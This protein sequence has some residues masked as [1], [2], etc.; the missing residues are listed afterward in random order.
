MATFVKTS[1]QEATI[2]SFSTLKGRE[3]RGHKSSV[4]TVGWSCDGRKLASGSVDKTARIWAPERLYDSRSSNS[5][6]LRG[7]SESVDQLCWDPTH[8]DHLATASGDKTVRIWDA[9][10]AKSIHT[11]A[12][13]GQN[14]NISWSPDGQHIAVGNKEDLITFIDTKTFKIEKTYAS[15]V[16]VN[17]I[18]WDPTGKLFCL[19]TG[20]G[21]IK[22]MDFTTMKEVVALPAHTANCYC[23]E[24]S[25]NGKYLAS[26]S[27]DA[28]VNLWDL[29]S[30]T[31]VRT[32]GG[33][34]WPIR[35]ISF[36]HDG[37][38]LASAS[39]DLAIEVSLV[40][41]GETVHRI[42][43][44]AAMNTVAWHPSKYLLAYAGEE[45]ESRPG[46]GLI[47]K[48]NIRV[49]GYTS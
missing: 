25:P 14:I 8:P 5:F 22:I 49:W 26:G 36:S 9:R 29:E 31:C 17:E 21:S 30:Y 27:A 47:S 41:T 40:E 46:G 6:E 35:T 20:Q 15:R 12:T 42:E 44:F 39:E 28:L 19:T 37:E 43:C 10:S 2:A 33:L 7:H 13:N 24:F 34:D 1:Q 23:L 11:I 16:E 3:Y 38:F 32:F 4:H 18:S 45:Q 48:G